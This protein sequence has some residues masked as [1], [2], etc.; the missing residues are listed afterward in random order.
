MKTILGDFSPHGAHSRIFCA[1]GENF[2]PAM[3]VGG[4]GGT[5]PIAISMASKPVATVEGWVN[6][7]GEKPR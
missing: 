1:P 7:N 2:T 4:R 3:A 5:I 6:L